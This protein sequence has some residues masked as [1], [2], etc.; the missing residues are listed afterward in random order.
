MLLIYQDNCEN[1]EWE[2]VRSLLGEV[3]MSTVEAEKHRISFENSH[4]VI[5]VLHDGKLIG[6]GRM[7]SDGVRQSAI[8]DVAIAPDYQGLGIGKTIVNKLIACTPN[9]NFVLYASPG[10]EDFY[11]K[12]GFKKM[13]TGMILFTDPTKK[14]DPSFVEN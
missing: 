7:I 4:S 2:S 14:D 10:K 6:M 13:K 11:R 8:Y 1:I 12:L 5:F 3:G 9:C